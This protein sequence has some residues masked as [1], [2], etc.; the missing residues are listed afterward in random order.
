MQMSIEHASAGLITVTIGIRWDIY[1]RETNT[2][3]CFNH[4]RVETCDNLGQ[5]TQWCE[6]ARATA[7]SLTSHSHE[8]PS[9]VSDWD[10]EATCGNESLVS[11]SPAAVPVT[12]QATPASPMPSSKRSR[13]E[14]HATGTPSSSLLVPM[15]YLLQVLLPCHICTAYAASVLLLFLMQAYVQSCMSQ[16][17]Q[18]LNEHDMELATSRAQLARVQAQVQTLFETDVTAAA[19]D[20]AY[21]YICA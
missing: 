12:Q 20:N 15:L 10:Y 16:N 3:K 19:E 8:P 6:V 7:A 5:L 2:A 14:S 11:N 13:V 18:R 21:V 1:W 9:Y 4:F 17:A